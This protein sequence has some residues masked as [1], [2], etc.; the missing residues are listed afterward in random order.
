MRAGHH[1]SR[2]RR[3]GRSR[4]GRRDRERRASARPRTC[5]GGRARRHH[6]CLPGRR[7]ARIAVRRQHLRRGARAHQVLQHLAHPVRALR[8]MHRVCRPGGWLA[9]RD[10]DYAA[11]AWYPEVPEIGEWRST[12]RAI[13]RANGAQPD[14][15]RRLRAWAREAALPPDVRIT[16]SVWNYA[17]AASCRWW[18]NGQADRIEGATFTSQAGSIGIG[19]S[20]VQ[21]IGAA[22]RRWGEHSDA[23]FMIPHGGAARPGLTRHGPTRGQPGH[24]RM[25]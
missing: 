14:A 1:H 8:E 4:P 9:A 21:A 24:G 5:G 23:W 18:G 15:G 10:A 6:D 2:P 25:R 16:A 17:D 3:G 20:R 12:Y 7:R 13:A 22:W 11:M 19:P